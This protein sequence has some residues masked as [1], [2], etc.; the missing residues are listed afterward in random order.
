MEC[1][2]VRP[3]RLGLLQLFIPSLVMLVDQFLQITAD[4]V[5]GRG[6]EGQWD[7]TLTGRFHFFLAFLGEGAGGCS[8]T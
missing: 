2:Q 5:T 7:M 3:L 1:K 6:L 4:L 8:S